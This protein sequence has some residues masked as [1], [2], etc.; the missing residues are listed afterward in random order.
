MTDQRVV[1]KSL[2]G[3]DDL[4]FGEGQEVQTRAGG[5]Y[6]IQKIRLTYPVNSLTELNALDP[7]QFPKAT[8]YE[9]NVMSEYQYNPSTEVYDQISS[10]KVLS[11][12]TLT[13]GQTTVDAINAYGDISVTGPDVNGGSLVFTTDYTI[14]DSD[15][16]ELAESYPAGTILQVR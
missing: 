7:E 9:N 4:L 13:D 3:Q 12:T 16:I 2:G 14:T 1:R 11:S 8:L 15:T 5:S 10:V 6:N